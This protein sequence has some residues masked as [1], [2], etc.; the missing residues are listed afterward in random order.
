MRAPQVRIAGQLGQRQAGNQGSEEEME[1]R[2]RFVRE[3][4]RWLYREGAPEGQEEAKQMAAEMAKKVA[5]E[6]G[7]E[8]AADEA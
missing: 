7:V 5:E 8:A 6:K 2:S 3:E 1:E 4:G